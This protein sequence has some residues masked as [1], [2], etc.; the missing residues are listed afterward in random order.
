[1]LKSVLESVGVRKLMNE[2]R[3]IARLYLDYLGQTQE[4]VLCPEISSEEAL[5]AL[6]LTTS[7]TLRYV[8]ERRSS[9]GIFVLTYTG[10]YSGQ[11]SAEMLSD[12]V[13]SDEIRLMNANQLVKILKATG[14]EV[15]QAKVNTLEEALE[16]ATKDARLTTPVEFEIRRRDTPLSTTRVVFRVKPPARFRAWNSMSKPGSASD[17]HII[18]AYHPVMDDTRVE[19]WL[20]NGDTDSL[21]RGQAICMVYAPGEPQTPQ[22]R[23]FLVSSWVNLRRPYYAEGSEIA[24]DMSPTK[25]LSS[26][27]IEEIQSVLLAL[28][29][30][31]KKYLSVYGGFREPFTHPQNV[32]SYLFGSNNRKMA[33]GSEG[34]CVWAYKVLR[35]EGSLVEA[36]VPDWFLSEGWLQAYKAYGM[37]T[38]S[39]MP[40]G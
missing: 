7:H 20:V 4:L 35:A 29:E 34:F 40:R 3:Q 25:S 21:I 16:I 37:I 2:G 10:T 30:I 11:E 15:I 36:Y 18:P 39:T 32:V 27:G 33:R 5:E 13:V 14:V 8:V 24:V 23:G 9:N 6:R 26:E 1:M 19:Y 12:G 38:L 28:L 31:D 17:L 22:N